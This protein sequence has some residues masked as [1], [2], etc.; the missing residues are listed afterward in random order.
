VDASDKKAYHSFLKENGEAQ[1]YHN[2]VQAAV[3]FTHYG[4][5]QVHANA[6]AVKTGVASAYEV[7]Y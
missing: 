6:V 2:K 4:V 1:F 7:S 5:P 3:H